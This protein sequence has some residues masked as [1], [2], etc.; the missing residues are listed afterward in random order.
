MAL[1][2]DKNINNCYSI[3]KIKN[4]AGV[5]FGYSSLDVNK[6]LCCIAVMDITAMSVNVI[7]IKYAAK[8]NRTYDENINNE[9]AAFKKTKDSLTKNPDVYL[10]S[11]HGSLS[12]N[13][14]NLPTAASNICCEPCIGV[15]CIMPDLSGT[16]VES[17][18]WKIPGVHR[19][20]HGNRH[21][22]CELSC[23][24]DREPLYV[25]VGS[26]FP[27]ETASRIVRMSV[28][29]DT[30]EIRPAPLIISEKAIEAEIGKTAYFT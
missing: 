30:G 18:D 7:K 3:D 23:F 25:S 1:Y 21:I 27:L 5:S 2:S 6:I 4:V 16:V 22:A 19:I 8:C 28:K 29:I 17:G 13:K 15:T 9:L 14:L 10:F 12:G 20:M 24:S 26:S 11:R